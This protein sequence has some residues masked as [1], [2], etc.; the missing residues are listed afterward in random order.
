MTKD[1]HE[2]W[3]ESGR[4]KER[5]RALLIE[6]G[7]LIDRS[8]NPPE[9]HVFAGATPLCVCPVC[10]GKSTASWHL[11]GIKLEMLRAA[12]EEGA[13]EKELEE[14]ERVFNELTKKNAQP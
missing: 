4:D 3:V 5:Y 14:V 2:L 9:P 6:N 12:R 13:T 10:G 11:E 8:D 1:P 7:L